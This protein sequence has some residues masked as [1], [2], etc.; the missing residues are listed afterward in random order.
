MEISRKRFVAV[1]LMVA[2]AS[3]LGTYVVMDYSWTQS[4]HHNPTLKANVFIIFET[5]SGKDEFATGNVIT[6]IGENYTRCAFS[7]G[8]TWSKVEYISIGNATASASLTQLTTEYDRKQGTI[9]EWVNNGDYAFNVTYKWTFSSTV[10][11]NCAG[12]HWGSSGDGNL[13][14]VANFPS[15]AQ[16]FNSGDNCTVK[17][18]FTYDAN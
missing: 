7:R 17:W 1:V 11:L 5:A 4:L 16:T 8:G 14:A 18:V 2:V 15:G 9:A 3:A 13:Y 10:T 12:A 6:N